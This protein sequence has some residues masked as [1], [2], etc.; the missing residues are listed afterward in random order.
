M[1]DKITISFTHECTKCGEELNITILEVNNIVTVDPCLNCANK[2]AYQH[3]KNVEEQV[4]EGMEKI[5]RAVNSQI[6][7]IITEVFDD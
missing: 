5:K 2:M 6:T 7:Q 3:T 4:T 1:G